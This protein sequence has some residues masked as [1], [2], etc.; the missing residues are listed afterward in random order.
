MITEVTDKRVMSHQQVNAEFDG[1]W[2]ILDER[3]FSPPGGEG[4]LV[5]YGDG[6]Q[7]DYDALDQLLWDRFDGRALILKGYTPKEDIVYGIYQC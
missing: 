3:N 5:A 6:T 2:V 7:E 4:Y 1:R